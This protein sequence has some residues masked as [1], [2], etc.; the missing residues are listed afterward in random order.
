LSNAVGERRDKIG[1]TVPSSPAIR[2]GKGV[3]R[4]VPSRK[5]LKRDSD[6]PEG[7]HSNLGKGEL[8]KHKTLLP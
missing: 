3:L 2:G 4:A 5:E 7:E 6:K 1:M 8:V